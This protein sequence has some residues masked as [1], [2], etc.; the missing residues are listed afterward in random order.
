MVSGGERGQNCEAS[1]IQQ[2]N[3]SAASGGHYKYKFRAG[4]QMNS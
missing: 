1:N 4:A 2:Y 3:K